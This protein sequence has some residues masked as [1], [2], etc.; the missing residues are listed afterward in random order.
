MVDN[1]YLN[2]HLSSQPHLSSDSR[3]NKGPPTSN[4]MLDLRKKVFIPV[5]VIATKSS[6]TRHGGAN[7]VAVGLFCRFLVQHVVSTFNHA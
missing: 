7:R 2:D 4:T 3:S 5:F 6:T 1:P